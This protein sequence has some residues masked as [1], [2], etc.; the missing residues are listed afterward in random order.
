MKQD[1][2]TEG[3][4]QYFRQKGKLSKGLAGKASKEGTDVESAD[5]MDQGD[6]GN[7]GQSCYCPTLAARPVVPSFRLG[8]AAHTC[9]SSSWKVEAGKSGVQ[10]QPWLRR[11]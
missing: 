10:G 4:P 1:S 8:M 9:N 11:V 3:N 5:C 7:L 2:S 6:T